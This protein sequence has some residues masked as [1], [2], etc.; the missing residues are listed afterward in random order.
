LPLLTN[1]ESSL[2]LAQGISGRH[3]K[4]L[5]KAG[6]AP[7][8][9]V[10]EFF[11]ASSS[12]RIVAAARPDLV[13]ALHPD[14]CTEE[15]VDAALAASLPFAVVPCCVF[16]RLFAGRRL[17]STGERVRTHGQLCEFLAA[18]AVGTERAVLGFA[19]KPDVVFH[20]GGAVMCTAIED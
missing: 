19:G 20:R 13:V 2:A 6:R 7:F 9:V 12:A 4:R 5:K 1:P 16:S 15:V 3:R 11:D 18:K 17:P 14:E 8:G 10:R